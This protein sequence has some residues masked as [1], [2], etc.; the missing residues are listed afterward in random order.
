[1]GLGKEGGKRGVVRSSN[2]ENEDGL[3]IVG[4]EENG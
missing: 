2:D 1:M 4:A 3:E